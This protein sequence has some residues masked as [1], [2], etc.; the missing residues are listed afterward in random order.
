MQEDDDSTAYEPIEQLQRPLR[1]P[2]CAA[3][4]QSGASGG[5]SQASVEGLPDQ[6]AELAGHLSYHSMADAGAWREL[7]LMQ[8]L[9]ACLAA[10]RR[11]PRF[12]EL[13][14]VAQPLLR[15]ATDRLVAAP[16][17]LEAG[18]PAI[19]DALG[20]PGSSSS[21]TTPTGSSSGRGG[22]KEDAAAAE[23]ALAA[24]VALAA[25]VTAPAARRPLWQEVHQRLLPLAAQQLEQQ[26]IALARQARA[27]GSG[28]AGQVQPGPQQLY[29]IALPCQLV[30]FYVLQAPP[31]ALMPTPG[32]GSGGAS[33]VHEALLRGGLLRSLVLLFV[34]LGGQPG[35]EPLR[36]TLLLACTAGQ[37][38]VDWAAA[39]PG[40]A[41][42]VAAPPLQP[43]GDAQLHGAL[44]QVLLGHGGAQLA[45][46]LADARPADKVGGRLCVSRL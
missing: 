29:R 9:A 41:T 2:A 36:C 31:A 45:A 15:L 30:Y 19:M 37:P 33:R 3:P 22:A 17:E 16:V 1:L 13:E 12:L 24:A 25:Q 21:T 23:L 4:L 18:L 39:V 28:G 7:R 32:S 40:F 26:Q 44:W 11:H 46:L 43:G 20:V 38:L 8:R 34:Q 10:A 6:L 14:G 42:A 27:G 5:G 35:V